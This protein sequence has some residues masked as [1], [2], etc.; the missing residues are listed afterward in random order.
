MVPAGSAP[1]PCGC[2]VALISD[3]K[4]KKKVQVCHTHFAVF[5]CCVGLLIQSEL[6]PSTKAPWSFSPCPP[7]AG[8]GGGGLG[9]DGPR[10]CQGGAAPPAS[11]P[12]A[13]GRRAGAPQMGLRPQAA[14]RSS[15]QLGQV[16]PCAVRRAWGAQ[17][18]DREPRSPRFRVVPVP[19]GP[20]EGA[21]P[22]SGPVVPCPVTRDPKGHAE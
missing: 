13:S 11:P 10:S 9:Q 17:F 3:L 21:S 20:R 19:R 6:L 5:S 12:P 16:L 2:S 4:K 1:S 18:E 8:G 22:C 7:P 15:L 14:P